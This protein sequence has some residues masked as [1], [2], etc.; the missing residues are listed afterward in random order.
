MARPTLPVA[1]QAT[2]E[3]HRS[4]WSRRARRRPWPTSAGCARGRGAAG[5][6]VAHHRTVERLL[7]TVRR[8]GTSTT[9]KPL[10]STRCEHLDVEGEAVDPAEPEHATGPTSER[11]AFS[12]HWV[13][14]GSGRGARPSARQLMTAAAEARAGAGPARRRWCPG[15]GGCRR[16]RPSRPRPRSMQPGELV[17][18][19]GEVGVGEG[20][21]A[22]PAP[23]APRPARP[24]PCPGWSAARPPGRRRRASA[25][26]AVPSVDRRRP[27]RSRGRRRPRRGEGGA[28]GAR[29]WRRCRRPR[30]RRGCTTGGPHDAGAGG[31]V[32][33]STCRVRR[34]TRNSTR[35]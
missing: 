26:S 29:P 25:A 6:A 8:T 15:G 33:A 32:D 16:R 5:N 10:R 21:G 11:N 4:A 24:R 7:S 31:R 3:R 23:P 12:P 19:V 1:A 14:C 28:D 34:T 18:R 13:S 2:G 22:A 30:R 9:E 27:R 17:G 35:R 20:D